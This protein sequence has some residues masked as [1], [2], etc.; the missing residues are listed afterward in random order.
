MKDTKRE[1]MRNR[2]Q[3]WKKKIGEQV[4]REIHEQLAEINLVDLPRFEKKK[5]K[6][7]HDREIEVEIGSK[8]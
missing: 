7:G 8:K 1:A 3:E 2:K 6:K 4:A 5:E